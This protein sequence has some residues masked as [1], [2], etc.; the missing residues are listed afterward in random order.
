MC[1]SFLLSP[2]VAAANDEAMSVAAD[3]QKA[4]AEI[5][6]QALV[7]ASKEVEKQAVCYYA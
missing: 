1:L 7:V 6:K 4:N 5:E 3:N 2:K